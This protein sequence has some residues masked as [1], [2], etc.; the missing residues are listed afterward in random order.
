M[1][2]N[3]RIKPICHQ[4][5]CFL[6][7][8]TVS[9]LRSAESPDPNEILLKDFR[10]HSLYHS[11]E[12]RIDHARYPAIDLHTH[13]YAKT[14]EDVAR[15]VRVMDEVGVERSM[16][17]TYSVGEKFDDVARRFGKFPDR[18]SLWCGFDYSGYDQPGYGPAAVKE[19]ERCHA[20][21]AIGVGELGDKGKGLFYGDTKAWGMHLDDPRMDSLLEKC[22]DLK[23]P[24]S[25]HVADP[26]WMYEP[27]DAHNDGLM[28][29]YRW[30]LDNQ[31]GIV[32]HRGMI[33]ILESAVRRHP[34]T[35]FIA[36]HLANCSYDLGI[37]GRLF[38]RYPNLY[39]DI[40]A[41]FAE[42]APVPRYAKQFLEKYQDRIVYG[43]DMTFNPRMYRLT[44]RILESRDDHFYAFDQFS[45]HWPLNGLDLSDA[46]L[47]KIY[48][49]NALNILGAD[50]Q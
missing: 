44:F 42:L 5:P 35:T 28:N 4:L 24:V 31:P 27:M 10:P 17:L 18:F 45:Y 15:W 25:I 6:L 41:R 3:M 7:I 14:D 1:L 39:A 8:A 38:D 46:A 13:P 32:S 26:I 22:A 9:S 23:M 19:L 49:D 29:A 12:T 36:C 47:K 48:R 34:R 50:R 40:G 33:Q 21:G 43:T 20:Q 30:R 37:L 16:I 11:G 2:R